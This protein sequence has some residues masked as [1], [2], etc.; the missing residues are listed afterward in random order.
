[1]KINQFTKS[2]VAYNTSKN[3]SLSVKKIMYFNAKYLFQLELMHS[4]LVNLCHKS[5]NLEK[6]TTELFFYVY[7]VIVYKMAGE[8]FKL[9]LL[10]NDLLF[11]SIQLG[12]CYE[13][14]I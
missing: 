4:E 13:Y 14:K 2:N 5:P 6:R 11:L 1:M 10:G 3:T 7:A 8:P 9:I 12:V